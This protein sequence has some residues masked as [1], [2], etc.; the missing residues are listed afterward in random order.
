MRLELPRPCAICPVEI[1]EQDFGRADMGAPIFLIGKQTTAAH[2]HHFFSEDGLPGPD[3]EKN[4]T[5]LALTHGQAEGWLVP[6]LLPEKMAPTT[7]RLRVAQAIN[8]T[9]LETYWIK[10]ACGV[11]GEIKVTRFTE[12]Y[13]EINRLG[14]GLI[15]TQHGASLSGVCPDCRAALDLYK[16]EAGHGQ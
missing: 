14:W 1:T 7:T 5:R 11:S 8:I 2:A 13:K 9:R 3:Y 4:L 6:D 16:G 12:I 10:C 15:P